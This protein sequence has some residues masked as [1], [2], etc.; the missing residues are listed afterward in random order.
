MSTAKTTVE[1]QLHN[2]S[3]AVHAAGGKRQRES[4]G[5]HANEHRI[6]QEEWRPVP[7][8]P[9]LEASSLGRIRVKPHK[10]PMPRGGF[11][12]CGGQPTKGQWSKT[13]RRYVYARRGHKTLKV[14]RLVCEAFNGPKPF[15]NAVA[16]H[17]NEN[18]RD[19][20]PCNLKW[21]TQKANLNYPGFIAYCKRRTG[22]DNPH[23]KGKALGKKRPAS[24]KPPTSPDGYGEP[25]SAA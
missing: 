21:G 8:E 25:S 5:E 14:A 20:R 10:V 3:A 12:T 6:D 2:H 13:E 22:K 9:D 7:S 15:K 19:N 16:M 18:S 11:R 17:D 24:D 4:S 1:N 23:V